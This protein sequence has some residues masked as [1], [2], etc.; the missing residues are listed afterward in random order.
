M[1]QQAVGSEVDGEIG[2]LTLAAVASHPV[3]EALAAYAEVRRRRYRALPTF[4]RF[5]RGWLSRVDTTLALANA[6]DRS[7]PPLVPSQPKGPAPMPTETAPAAPSAASDGKW[8]GN[9]MTIQGILV[10]TLSTV[11]PV[12]ARFS[13]STSRP[14]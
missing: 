7:M 10:T 4:W 6:I 12:L 13:A 1:L 14:S 8:W 2:P 5:G 9:S 11:L 3:E